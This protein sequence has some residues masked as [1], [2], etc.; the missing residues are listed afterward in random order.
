M[1]EEQAVELTEEISAIEVVTP[2][3]ESHEYYINREISLI[4]FQ[5]RVLAEA[6]S[7]KYPLLERVKFLAYVFHNLDEFFMVR[8]G[9]LHLQTLAQT[10]LTL[11]IMILAYQ[12][13]PLDDLTGQVINILAACP[14]QEKYRKA[15][16][17]CPGLLDQ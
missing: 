2:N 12:N 6:K 1:S 7:Q 3:L 8:V 15:L 10:P 17:A 9:G 13:I 16:Y 11:G 14:N 4:D 5:E